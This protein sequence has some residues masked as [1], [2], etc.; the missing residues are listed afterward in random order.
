M[1]TTALLLIYDNDNDNDDA[2]TVMKCSS[3]AVL[4]EGLFPPW[5]SLIAL[6]PAAVDTVLPSLP[7]MAYLLVFKGTQYI[8]QGKYDCFNVHEL[9]GAQEMVPSRAMRFAKLPMLSTSVWGP[10]ENQTF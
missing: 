9:L 5:G 3:Q 4:W 7:A 10:Q 8:P 6:H 1:R 2:V